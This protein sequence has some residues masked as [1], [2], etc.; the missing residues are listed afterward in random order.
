MVGVILSLNRW[1]RLGTNPLAARL[2]ERLPAGAL[3]VVAILLTG[4]STVMYALPA[5]LALFFLGRILWGFCWSLLRLGSFLAALEDASA[6][7]GRRIGNTR[8]IWGIGYLG[9]A[10]YAPF[11]VEAW[12]WTNACL[13]AA[14]LSIA[15]GIGPALI[16]SS[17]RRR[18]A[19]DAESGVPASVWQSRYLVLFVAAT[20]Q[21]SL[22]AGIVVAAGGFRIDELFHGGAPI[23]ATLVPATFIAAGFALTQRIA[24]VAWTPIAGRW[25]DRSTSFAFVASTLLSLVSIA[26]L[27][28]EPPALLFVLFGGSAFVNGLTATIAVELAVARRSREIDRPR[29]L[30]ALHT[31][32]DAGAAAG[33]LAGG[34]LAAF[35]ASAALLAGAALLAL[36][37]PLW[38]ASVVRP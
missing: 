18:V 16:A 23:G 6:H 28:A 11:A 19:I 15:L 30:A 12:G 17:W 20:I 31:W 1:V 3:I 4:V 29:I 10:V 2:Y 24:Q 33:A 34:V 14:A 22:F 32:Q 26:A 13:V 7:A 27:V 37:L 36:T 8:A 35:G 25:S 38:W 5:A 21:F 9:G